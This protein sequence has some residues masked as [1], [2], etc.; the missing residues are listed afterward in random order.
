MCTYDVVKKELADI[1]PKLEDIRECLAREDYLIAAIGFALQTI[2][3]YEII[4]HDSGEIIKIDEILKH[5]RQIAV[6]HNMKGIIGKSAKFDPITTFYLMYRYTYGDRQAQFDS[7]K[8]LAQ[9]CGITM[10]DYSIIKKDGGMI[11]VL[12]PMER[13]D[14]DK[15]PEESM[16]DILHKAYRL[17]RDERLDESNGLL[18]KYNMKNNIQFENMCKALVQ[19]VPRVTFESTEL[20]DFMKRIGIYANYNHKIDKNW[21]S[22]DP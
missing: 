21:E 15:I 2:T 11:H 12:N 5:T 3:K 16:I 14:T 4:K 10:T 20:P 1:L 18:I 7:V 17:R 19:S 8:K 22:L 13:G 6:Q 9:G